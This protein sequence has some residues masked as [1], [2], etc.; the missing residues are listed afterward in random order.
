MNKDNVLKDMITKMQ[1]EIQAK[2]IDNII[3]DIRYN[4]GGMFTHARELS[5]R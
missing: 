4:G 1:N 2:D 3:L 5:L